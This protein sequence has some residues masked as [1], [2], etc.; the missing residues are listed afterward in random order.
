MVLRLA[1]TC[2]I[3]VAMNLNSELLAVD[4]PGVVELKVH[5]GANRAGQRA[6]G[7]Y[8]GHHIVATRHWSEV[9]HVVSRVVFYGEATVCPAS[10]ASIKWIA[11]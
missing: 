1:I 5:G 7:M 2:D 4:A 11:D 10:A 8:F 6:S 9:L 3:C